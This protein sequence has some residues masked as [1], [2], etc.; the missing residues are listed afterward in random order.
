[1]EG[2]TARATISIR[3][4]VLE[5]AKSLDLNLSRAAEAGIRNEISKTREQQWLEAHREAIQVNNARIEREGLPL[6][7]YRQF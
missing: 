1:M 6:A 2:G 4:D 5:E 7:K 3:V